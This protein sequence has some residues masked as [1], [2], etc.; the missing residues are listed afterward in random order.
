M[1]TR[2]KGEVFLIIGATAFALNGIVAKMVM[3][4]GLSEWRMLQVRTGGAFL[5]LLAYVL[6]T[7]YKSLKVKLNEWPLLITYSLIGFALVQFGYFIAISRMHVSMALIIE[8]TAPI[9]IVLWIKYVRKSF[10]PKDMWIAISLAFVGM[11]LLAQVWD[12]MT[13]DTLGVI[14]A[15]LDAFALATFFVLSERLTPT[16]STYSL[17]VFGFGI[18]SA[19]LSIVFPLWNFPFKIFNQSMNLEGP[20][21]DSNAPGWTLIL[22]IVVLG[23]VIPY[24]CVLAG[25]KILSASTSSVIGMLEPVLAGIF[26]WIWIGESWNAI[27]LIGGAIV[28][29]GI[30][31]ADKT[32]SKVS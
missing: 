9:W 18:S 6:L 19:L 15:F 14:A 10:V 1:F 7:N 26:A 4:N 5:V 13:L 29:A 12:G 24:L 16:R 3:Q 27:Q 22:W 25:I 17:T 28:I 21:K 30:Y 32:R 31:I 2:H 8:F 20:L 11:L 23:T